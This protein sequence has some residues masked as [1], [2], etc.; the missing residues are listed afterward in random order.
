ML[1]AGP[2]IDHS[3][4]LV[5]GILKLTSMISI[6]ALISKNPTQCSFFLLSKL[7]Y[8]CFDNSRAK[9]NGKTAVFSVLSH[10][11][12]LPWCVTWDYSTSKVI[13]IL[14]C[15]CLFPPLCFT[16]SL[17]AFQYC[18]CQHASKYEMCLSRLVMIRLL[19]LMIHDFYVMNI[20]HPPNKYKAEELLN[21]F[22]S[23]FEVLKHRLDSQGTVVRVLV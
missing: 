1:R 13:K 10:Y 14:I 5:H 3:Q 20:K 8:N 19:S 9:G 18:H 12:T 21:S 6:L 4:S 2:C 16:M 15:A 23:I 17:E 7:K 11:A 22:L